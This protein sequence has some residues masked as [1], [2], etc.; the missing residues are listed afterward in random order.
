[1]D[2]LTQNLIEYHALGFCSQFGKVNEDTESQWFTDGTTHQ[3]DNL[4]QSLKHPCGLF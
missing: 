4:L 1:M 2:M 3:N